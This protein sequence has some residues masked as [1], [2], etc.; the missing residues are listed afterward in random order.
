MEN[1]GVSYDTTFWKLYGEG[2]I[3]TTEGSFTDTD[4]GNYSNEDI[5]FT[6]KN[7]FLYAFVLNCFEKDMVRITTLGKT[8]GYYYGK[9][10]NVECLDQSVN[11][12]FERSND[13]L[14]I[15]LDKKITHS[16]PITLKITLD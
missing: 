2:S 15:K 13:D 12:S 14:L 9:I 3:H 6:F 10:A 7:G 11:L 4:R 1:V 8:K 16:N 5:R